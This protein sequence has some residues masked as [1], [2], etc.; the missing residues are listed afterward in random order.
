[1]TFDFKASKLLCSYCLNKE[2]IEVYPVRD[3]ITSETFIAKKCINCGLVQTTPKLSNKQLTK[4]YKGYRES[5][6]KRFWQP[7]EYVLN[8]WHIRR[9]RG[10]KKYK[11]KGVVLDIGCGRGKE[12]ELLHKDG[13]IVYGTEFSPDLKKTL[14]KRNINTFIG[15]FWSA[16]Y[17]SNFFD[18][19][20]LWHSLEHLNNINLV[21]KEIERIL[22]S[23]GILIIAVP[24]FNSLEQKFFDKHWFHLDVPRHTAHFSDTVLSN[25]LNKNGFKILSKGY[26][27]PEYDFYSFCQSGLNKIFKRQNFLYRILNKDFSIGKQRLYLLIHLWVFL[28]LAVIS[29]FIVPLAWFL[30]RG[31]TVEIISQKK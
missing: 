18:V 24:N 20:T 12:L 2:L 16:K 13:W 7:V 26:I 22:K 23:E 21:F 4:Y 5:T 25:I 3:Y 27:A 30:K 14:E 17:E 19:I 1:M 6:G 10:I 28:S 11:L 9:V 8:Y 15:D 31:G 29:L